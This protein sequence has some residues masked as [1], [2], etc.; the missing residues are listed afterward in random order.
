M[1]KEDE[2]NSKDLE[3]S[4]LFTEYEKAQDSAEHHDRLVW[5]V[6]SIIF[7]CMAILIGQI[8][9]NLSDIPCELLILIGVLGIAL[10]LFLLICVLSF[11]NIKEQKYKRCREIENYL[12]ENHLKNP[13]SKM[14]NHSGLFYLPN[15]QLTMYIFVLV[16]FLVIWI[17]ILTTKVC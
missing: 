6:S 13:K 5:E 17:M 1:N 4:A 11:R 8:V 12:N 10:C 9:T 15:I 3:F 16:I 2:H 14:K 7:G